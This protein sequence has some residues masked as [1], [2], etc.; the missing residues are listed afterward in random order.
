VTKAGEGR[1]RTRKRKGLGECCGEGY[2]PGEGK[3]QLGGKKVRGGDVM[4]RKPCKLFTTFAE[5]IFSAVEGIARKSRVRERKEGFPCSLLVASRD[6][7][8]GK[9]LGTWA[10]AGR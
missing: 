2:W 1:T 5:T 7:Y 6:N 10:G 8:L 9:L 3:V 4:T